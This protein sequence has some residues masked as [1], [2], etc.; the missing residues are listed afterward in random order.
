LLISRFFQRLNPDVVQLVT[1]RFGNE[2]QRF[3]DVFCPFQNVVLAGHVE[4]F[5]PLQNHHPVFGKQGEAAHP[6]VESGLIEIIPVKNVQ[7]EGPVLFRQNGLNQFSDE[8]FF[9]IFFGAVQKVEAFDVSTADG[10]ELFFVSV[11]DSSHACC[12]QS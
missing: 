5:E 8:F 1:A 9:E 10:I 3:W 7:V 6:V 11:E 2:H 12:H 4:I